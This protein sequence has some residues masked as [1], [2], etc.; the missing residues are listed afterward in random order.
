V[1]LEGLSVKR[2]TVGYMQM[3][4]RNPFDTHNPGVPSYMMWVATIYGNGDKTLLDVLIPLAQS[5]KPARR[6]RSGA[7]VVAWPTRPANHYLHAGSARPRR[8]AGRGQSP[9]GSTCWFRSRSAK[10]ATSRLT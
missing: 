4:F 10:F 6:R 9:T 1:L 7:R 3:V 8:R 2:E 5:A